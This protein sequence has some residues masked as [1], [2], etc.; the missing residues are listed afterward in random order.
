MQKHSL[1]EK[2]QLEHKSLLNLLS[3]YLSLATFST[4]KERK[5]LGKMLINMGCSEALDSISL[6]SIISLPSFHILSFS[7]KRP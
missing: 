3:V 6:N 5:V 2:H 1:A 7:F 4:N